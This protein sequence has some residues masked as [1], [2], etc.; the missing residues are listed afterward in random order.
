[1]TMFKSVSN[2]RTGLYRVWYYLLHKNA[3][4]V[5]GRD[6]FNIS[7]EEDRSMWYRP[8]DELRKRYGNDA[9]WNGK[10]AVTYRHYLISPDPKDKC[11]LPTL[12]KL[13]AR[14]VEKF[15]SE[16]QVA[17]VY[18]DDN[19]NGIPHAHIIVNNTNIVTGKRLRISNQMR[20]EAMPNLVQRLSYEL[21]L[22]ALPNLHPGKPVET[23][24]HDRLSRA[25]RAKGKGRNQAEQWRRPSW[26][27]QI[28]EQ[29]ETIAKEAQGPLSFDEFRGRMRACGYDA[30]RTKRG[31]TYVHPRGYIDKQGIEQ[32]WKVTGKRLGLKYTPYGMARWLSIGAEQPL[33]QDLLRQ[34]T[35]REAAAFRRYAE[36]YMS[37]IPDVTT[38]DRI[39]A[40]TV[41][42]REGINH[43][44]DFQEAIAR[45]KQEAETLSLRIQHIDALIAR[46]QN[47]LK[48]AGEYET[49][50]PTAI[51]LNDY[52]AAAG[53]EDI[54]RR[55]QL[56]HK[57]ELESFERARDALEKESLSEPSDIDGLRDRVK[58]HEQQRDQLIG[59]RESLRDRQHKLSEAAVISRQITEARLEAKE[60]TAV[61][62]TY[63]SSSQDTAVEK[64]A[65]RKRQDERGRA[66]YDVIRTKHTHYQKIETARQG[67]VSSQEN[68]LQR[69]AQ[70]ATRSLKRPACEHEPPQEQK[71]AQKGFE[72]R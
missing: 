50:L 41:I 4:Q 43:A 6:V 57:S 63:R 15:F 53:K 2:G 44:S 26:V 1:M 34:A 71:Q 18:H 8:M 47:L 9:S 62:Y 70:E 72:E 24:Q 35:K 59:E 11:D 39:N 14:W 16:Y 32:H 25:E 58:A 49:H 30:Y 17:A 60:K 40:F 68:L 52:L 33:A 66:Q 51:R 12:Q 56:A 27:A 36:L 45:L 65:I 5:L 61:Q 22:S 31:Y 69:K 21:G 7:K 54:A 48:L 38:Q 55:Y 64:V 10:Q 3:R 37:L 29:I 28:R 46:N 19:E 67:S 20:D 23:T 13:T 42:V